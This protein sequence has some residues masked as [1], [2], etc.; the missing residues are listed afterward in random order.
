MTDELDPREAMAA[1]YVLGTLDHGERQRAEDLIA[2]DA[3][4]AQLVDDWAQRLSPLAEA[5]DPVEPPDHV[6]Q[7]IQAALPADAPRQ[8]VRDDKVP[9]FDRLGFWRWTTAIACGAAAMLAVYIGTG[10]SIGPVQDKYVAV[11]NDERAN[12]AWLVTVDLREQNMTIRP[13]QDVTVADKS[14]ELW[15]IAEDAPQPVSLGLLSPEQ[16]IAIPIAATLQQGVPMGSALAVS[17]EPSGGSPTGLPTGPV[18]FQGALL[19]LD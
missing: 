3:G 19:N 6:W 8:A 4:F 7:G 17:L 15:I 14:Y 18:L 13:V 1:D 12:P 2:R 11:L 5:V 10:P 9:L 16:P